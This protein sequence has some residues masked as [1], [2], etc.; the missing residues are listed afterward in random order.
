[1][2]L[3]IQAIP[4]FSDNYIW[5]LDDGR[6]CVVVDPG[7]AGG[8]LD[9]LDRTGLELAG[10]LLTHHHHDHIGGVDEI[11][12]RQPAPVWA[13][14]G[15]RMPADAHTVAEGDTVR[16]DALGLEF[17]VLETP[18]HTLDHIAYHGD[19]R[20]FC[21]DTLFSAGCGRLFEG[22][23]E[24]MQE[25]LDRL[26][27]LADGTG[28]FCAHEY[29]AENIRFALAVEPDNP[30][31]RARA[32]EVARMRADDRIT[33]PSTIGAEKRFNPFLRTREPAVIEAAR[34]REPG[35]DSSPSAVF[36]VIRRWKDGF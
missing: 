27:A 15:D 34:R 20:L 13:P 30:A 14:A 17:R 12:R 7:E 4:A 18:G 31:L 22:T 16:I 25:S 8:V 19:G 32:D 1:M 5:A 35:C 36:G 23:P 11:R 10:V 26:A 6:H 24:Q 2:A 9:R 29:T 21:G 3:E 28:V 33:L